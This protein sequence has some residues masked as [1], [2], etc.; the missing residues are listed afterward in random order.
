MFPLNSHIRCLIFPAAALLY[1]ITSPA[2]MASFGDFPDGQLEVGQ[3]HAE[4]A[5]G[6]EVVA[7][8]V[9]TI[10]DSSGQPVRP[11]KALWI[12]S[13]G[14]AGSD[15][16]LTISR[17]DGRQFS[18]V[19]VDVRSADSGL[20]HAVDLIGYRNGIPTESAN[21]LA[22]S[23]VDWQ[24]LDPGFKGP[25]D[26]L[27]ITGADSG[28]A[29][30]VIDNFVFAGIPRL[31]LDR[32]EFRPAPVA[33]EVEATT[34]LESAVLIALQGESEADTLLT[35]QIVDTPA[36][37]IVDMIGQGP[38]VIYTPDPG[39]EEADDT[40]TYRVSDEFNDSSL[41]TVTVTVYPLAPKAHD[42]TTETSQDMPVVVTLEGTGH[43]SNPI[44]FD[45]NQP[46]NGTVS[47]PGPDVT[48]T[49]DPGF[50]GIDTFEFRVNDGFRDSQ[51]A[52][53]TVTVEPLP[54]SA[55]DVG[56]STNPETSVQ[57]TLAGTSHTGEPLTY[58]IVDEPSKGAVDLMDGGPDAIYTPD[59]EI[60]D[61]EDSFNYRVNDGFNDSN[62]AKV[63][64]AISPHPPQAHD[65]A[66]E[67]SQDLPLIITLE[68]T[69]NSTKPLSYHFDQPVNGTVTGMGPDV[70][71]TPNPGFVGEDSF[72]FW[73]NDGFNDS[74]VATVTIT[75]N[76]G[77]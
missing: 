9:F 61:D 34:E 5:F 31:F 69:N 68:A 44:T 6:A 56:A 2:Q 43:S 66:Q 25:I 16:S 1:A 52:T 33:G 11:G 41:A 4:G 17:L 74:N 45:Y 50:F 63:T 32:F 36:D 75:V 24:A 28:D 23:G 76:P 51:P 8:D 39:F 65:I 62:V 58:E 49:P 46:E 40:F 35:Y 60:A 48:Y 59:A 22:V 12:G 72:D 71:Y 55:G 10:A 57:I 47:G 53:V 18:L 27:H 21:G 73:V 15:D 20:S 67:T 64:M 54:P 42:V 77:P 7:G 13:Q 30:L 14:S 26:E 3:V 38:E 37:G 19:S 29:A 70:E